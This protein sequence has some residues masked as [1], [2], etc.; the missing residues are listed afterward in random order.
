MRRDSSVHLARCGI[1]E[2]TA[3]GDVALNMTFVSKKLTW[4]FHTW[5]TVL[6]R[7]CNLYG[8]SHLGQSD[9][10]DIRIRTS[11]TFNNHMHFSMSPSV[12]SEYAEMNPIE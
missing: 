2:T 11:S 12:V 4:T 9:G 10:K 7:F 5:E 3:N 6:V 1:V 8:Q